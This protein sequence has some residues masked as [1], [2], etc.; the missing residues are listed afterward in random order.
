M[1]FMCST[2]ITAYTAV[3]M[4]MVK[5]LSGRQ[6]V[7]QLFINLTRWLHTIHTLSLLPPPPPARIMET[8]FRPS[9]YN[10]EYPSLV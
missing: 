1:N 4:V 3:L 6:K 5:S 7:L 2:S 10:G 8:F 9:P